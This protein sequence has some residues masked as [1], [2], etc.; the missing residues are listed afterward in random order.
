MLMWLTLSES[1]D[2]YDN[3][4]DP[5]DKITFSNNISVILAKLW[6]VSFSLSHITFSI[7]DTLTL[8]P[9]YLIHLHL[10]PYI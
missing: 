4:S 9:L 3:T 10:H 2:G 1:L 6:L 5:D 7:F 8:T